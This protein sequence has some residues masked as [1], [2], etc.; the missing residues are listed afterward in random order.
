MGAKIRSAESYADFIENSKNMCYTKKK[1]AK[2]VDVY[3]RQD[4][5]RIRHLYD[6]V[7]QYSDS[8]DHPDST[9]GMECV[10]GFSAGGTSEKQ[11]F[12]D[13]ACTL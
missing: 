8:G 9:C 12:H 1:A 11:S 4:A 7:L 3:K 5:E 6:L 2:E 10:P 13:T